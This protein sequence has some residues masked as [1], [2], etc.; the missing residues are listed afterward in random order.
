[1]TSWPVWLEDNRRRAVE[2]LDSEVTEMLC[3]FAVTLMVIV[4]DCRRARTGHCAG[5]AK[6]RLTELINQTELVLCLLLTMETKTTQPGQGR[7]GTEGSQSSVIKLH[8]LIIDC[9]TDSAAWHVWP[10]RM[11][12]WHRCEHLEVQYSL[13]NCATCPQCTDMFST[14]EIEGIK[15][16]AEL[17]L[18]DSRS[19]LSVMNLHMV[20]KRKNVPFNSEWLSESISD[21]HQKMGCFMWSLSEFALCFLWGIGALKRRGREPT[22]GQRRAGFQMSVMT[23]REVKLLSLLLLAPVRIHKDTEPHFSKTVRETELWSFSSL[24][25]NEKALTVCLFFLVISHTSYSY[26][27]IVGR[28]SNSGK[29][30][31]SLII[32]SVVT[33]GV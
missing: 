18:L 33:L 15:P 20:K 8:P 16:E 2:G 29:E 9:D 25:N 28:K 6:V 12:C 21:L 11:M 32:V 1:M 7:G 13:V 22:L 5:T 31:N 14:I 10:R 3:D 19:R 30:I 23:N 26:L 4:R 24:M 27:L 17:R